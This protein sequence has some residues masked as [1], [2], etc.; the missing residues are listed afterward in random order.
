VRDGKVE[1]YKSW[2]ATIHWPGGTVDRASF[3][4]GNER[5]W[6]W[7][8]P[9]VKTARQ[10]ARQ[11][12]VNYLPNNP[13]MVLGAGME[14]APLPLSEE[15]LQNPDWDYPNTLSWE[16]HVK[17]DP[18]NYEN[19]RSPDSD[20]WD[21]ALRIIASRIEAG[22]PIEAGAEASVDI[23]DSRKGVLKVF[24]E[25]PSDKGEEEALYEA[26]SYLQGVVDEL[27]REHDQWEFI[28]HGNVG[29]SGSDLEIKNEAIE[30]WE[31]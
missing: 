7:M 11:W 13:R 1:S 4:E 16:V 14:D 23:R 28:F 17:S 25:Y 15:M 18:R 10:A 22:A 19:N 8:G 27:S 29:G 3:A 24:F 30:A 20:S 12:V 9:G 21:D 5:Q 31:E 6:R 26:E 2:V